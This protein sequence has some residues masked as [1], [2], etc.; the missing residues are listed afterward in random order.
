MFWIESKIDPIPAVTDWRVQLSESEIK[1]LEE[2]YR[3][4]MELNIANAMRDL[5]KRLVEPVKKMAETL[6]DPEKGFHKTL[7]TNVLDITKILP[8]L[9]LTEDKALEDMRREIERKLCGYS[10]KHLKDDSQ[11]RKDTAKAAQDIM[12]KM[13]AYMGAV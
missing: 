4:R 3:T 2:K 1:K 8:D 13:S 9:N 5:W 11:L 7:V 10:S 12:N 6:S